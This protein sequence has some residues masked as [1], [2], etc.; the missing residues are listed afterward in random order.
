MT[1]Q[2]SKDFLPRIILVPMDFGE[3]AEAALDHA[4]AWAR[5][6][7]AKIA[8]LHVCELPYVGIPDGPLVP[9]A[10]VIEPMLQDAERLLATMSAKHRDQG[11]EISSLVEQGVPRDAIAKVARRL[12][13]DLI[14]M[15]THGRRGIPRAL[16]G[17]VA[18]SIVRC[19]P[20]P[21]LTIHGGG[22][23]DA[24]AES[25]DAASAH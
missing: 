9:A 17:S 12:G 6:S 8:L 22:A 15:G 11:V 18:E 25:A 19:A 1:G 21:V 4:V 5:A 3:V 2:S 16:L 24:A 14:V 23:H 20:C 7:G 10:D 13:A